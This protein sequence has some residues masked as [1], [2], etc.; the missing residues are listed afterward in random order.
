MEK[1]VLKG[2]PDSTAGVVSSIFLAG[3]ADAEN[4]LGGGG[5]AQQKRKGQEVLQAPA[6]RMKHAR[7]L[8][9]RVA[10]KHVGRGF[11]TKLTR[12]NAN[13]MSGIYV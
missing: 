12:S 5:E 11:R 2:R 4:H 9:Y 13:T 10:M 6:D 1:R 8:D 3:K 7:S